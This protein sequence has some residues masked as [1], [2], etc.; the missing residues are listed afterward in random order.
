M[1]SQALFDFFFCNMAGS[2][3]EMGIEPCCSTESVRKQ[4]GADILI[5]FIQ[6]LKMIRMDK[7]AF[8]GLEHPH[9][10]GIALGVQG[11]SFG[12][13]YE[14]IARIRTWI[15]FQERDAGI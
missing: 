1:I 3:M 12:A 13:G 15:G 7:H 5:A 14:H 8:L 4:E 2:V 6:F 11:L 9:A 10:A